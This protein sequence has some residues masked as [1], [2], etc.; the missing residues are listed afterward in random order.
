MSRSSIA[1]F[2]R[3]ARIQVRA[4]RKVPVS[5]SGGGIFVWKALNPLGLGQI[6]TDLGM[7]SRGWALT[8][9]VFDL[10]LQAWLQA[11]SITGLAAYGLAARL[12]R[13][14]SPP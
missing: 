3:K 12:L 14:R 7:G 13:E 1:R 8:K 10:V 6:L 5:S 11:D 4:A 2:T 9:V